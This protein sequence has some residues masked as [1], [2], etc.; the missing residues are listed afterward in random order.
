MTT[1]T[2]QRRFLPNEIRQVEAVKR[3]DGDDEQL[4]LIRGT[5]IVFFNKSDPDGTQYQLLRNTFER[6][7]PGSLELSMARP[8]D[9]RA[10]QNHDP[11]MILGRNAAKTLKLTVDDTGQHYEIETPDTTVGRDTAVSLQRGDITGSSFAFSMHVPGAKAVWTEEKNED[12]DSI[13]YRQIEMIGAQFDVG[14]VTYPA[15]SGTDSGVRSSRSAGIFAT[16]SRAAEAE[17]ET[18]KAELA[19]F[20]RTNYYEPEAERRARELALINLS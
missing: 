8:D 16:E 19:D 14:P 4:P 17:I 18:V 2:I 9:V 10:L 5:G 7:M 6:I 3:M 11:R 13:Y 15:Y 20:L 12:N 1:A